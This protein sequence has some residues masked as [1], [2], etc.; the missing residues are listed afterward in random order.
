MS[1]VNLANREPLSPPL[2]RNAPKG[3][4]ECVKRPET[5]I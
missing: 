1:A 2:T 5:F 3:T 4:D